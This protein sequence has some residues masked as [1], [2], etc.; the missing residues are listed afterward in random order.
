MDLQSSDLQPTLAWT[1]FPRELVLGRSVTFLYLSQ[2]SLVTTRSATEEIFMHTT[3]LGDMI[4]H[5]LDGHLVTPPL[6]RDIPVR[7]PIKCSTQVQVFCNRSSQFRAPRH[8]PAM[9]HSFIVRLSCNLPR[10]GWGL[11]NVKMDKEHFTCSTIFTRGS[12]GCLRVI[13][14]L[15]IRSS[16]DDVGIFHPTVGS[17]YYRWRCAASCSGV[18]KDNRSISYNCVIFGRTRLE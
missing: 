16:I 2:A 11:V 15:Q 6:T 14:T 4:Y 12:C 13:I 18:R 17:R 5:E 9:E 1:C 8:S 3:C 10:H 7:M